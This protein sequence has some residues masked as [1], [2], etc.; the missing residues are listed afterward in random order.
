MA[1][2]IKATETSDS[3]EREKMLK[4]ILIYNKEDL[5]ATWAV[6]QWLRG[7]SLQ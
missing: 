2:F 4:E 5:A 1:T 3:N 7:K 6:L